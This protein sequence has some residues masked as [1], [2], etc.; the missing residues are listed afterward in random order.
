MDEIA[1]T[2][3]VVAVC[4]WRKVSLTLIKRKGGQVKQLLNVID[5]GLIN[6]YHGRIQSVLRAIYPMRNLDELKLW[7][8]TPS[9]EKVVC[10]FQLN[11]LDAGNLVE[12]YI[13]GNTSS[14][15]L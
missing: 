3:H 9:S 11:S 10:L 4:D 7:N 5:K 13:Y 15:E 6:K 14:T 8:S 1:A 12:K 2:S